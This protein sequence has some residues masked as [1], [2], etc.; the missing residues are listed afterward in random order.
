MDSSGNRVGHVD[1]PMPIRCGADSLRERPAGGEISKKRGHVRSLDRGPQ[2]GHLVGL[3]HT[4]HHWSADAHQA[5]RCLHGGTAFT[6]CQQAKSLELR[7]A[8]SLRWLWH[9]QRERYKAR[10]LFAPIDSWFTEGSDTIDLQ[11]AKTLLAELFGP[12]DHAGRSSCRTASPAASAVRR[13]L[14]PSSPVDIRSSR[15]CKVEYDAGVL[16]PTSCSWGRPGQGHRGWPG[17]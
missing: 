2:K 4:R 16:T 9:Q 3:G 5:K 13:Y 14:P 6:R 12:N 7:A 8:M 17:A 1:K 11:E 15:E 10:E